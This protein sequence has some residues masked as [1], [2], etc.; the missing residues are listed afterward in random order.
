MVNTFIA[1]F[2]LAEAPPK[3]DYAATS[4]NVFPNAPPRPTTNIQSQDGADLLELGFKDGLGTGSH[5]LNSNNT[6]GQ[7][8]EI[9]NPKNLSDISGH[10]DINALDGTYKG[11]FSAKWTDV[12]GRIWKVVSAFD[13]TVVPQ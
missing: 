10:V 5:T 11:D 3:P 2:I 6:Q 13:I 9:A 12:Q 8:G 7:Y 4:I 1:K